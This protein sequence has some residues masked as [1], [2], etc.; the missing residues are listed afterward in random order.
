MNYDW[1]YVGVSSA[2][3]GKGIREILNDKAIRFNLN[4]IR[5]DAAHF[6]GKAYWC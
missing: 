5:F 2:K 1:I 4:S 3:N 6:F